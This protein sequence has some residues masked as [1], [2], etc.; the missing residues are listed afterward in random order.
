VSLFDY[1]WMTGSELGRVDRQTGLLFEY[2]WVTGS[3]LGR[4]DRPEVLRGGVPS[5]T[6]R[7]GCRLRRRGGCR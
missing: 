4:V 2:M 7:V 3:G 6:C 1:M 5:V